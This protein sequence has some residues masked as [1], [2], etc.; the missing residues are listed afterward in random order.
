M[1][2]ATANI[3][4]E[5]KDV[6]MTISDLLECLDTFGISAKL[7]KGSP[8]TVITG[9]TIDSRTAQ[10]GDL[11]IAIKGTH[12]DGHSFI[13]DA[14]KKGA[15]AVMVE[16][17]KMDALETASV[18]TPG[19]NPVVIAVDDTHKAAAFAASAFYGFPTEKLHLTGVTGTNGKTSTTILIEAIYRQAGFEVGRIG[20]IGYCWKE[21]FI[22]AP[23]TTPDP[24]MLQRLFSQMVSD[25]VNRVVMEVSS[26]ALAQ[27]RIFG[28][29][30]DIAVFTNLSHDHLDFHETMEDYFE[31]KSLLFL[32]HLGRR[33]HAAMPAAAGHAVINID[34]PYG[35]RLVGMLEGKDV[36]VLTY[37]ISSPAHCGIA[38]L[39]YP[40]HIQ[41]CADST[42]LVVKTPIGEVSIRS[43]LIGRLNIYNILAAVG[44]GIASGIDL[45]II[46]RGI[47]SVKAVDGRLQK[48]SVDAPFHVIVDY[49]HT[50]DAMEK[51]LSC[52]RELAK[53]RVIT[54]FGC[55][56]DRDRTKRPLMAKVA[57]D[58]SDVVIITSD[59]PRTE[60]PQKIIDDILAGMPSDWVRDDL[61]L[62]KKV[63]SV[64]IDRRAAIK[65]A[66]QIAQP[67]D[68]VFIGGKGHET[69]QIIGREKIP[70]DDRCVVKECYDE[71]K[72][73]CEKQS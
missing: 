72:E 34:D 3:A 13:P 43:N 58:F 23:L 6:Q 25:G 53:G 44:A 46:A 36:E 19:E 2:M 14:I 47:A 59:N 28:C 52:V 1:T 27:K 7:V 38:P 31:A 70:F 39:I 69:Y 64:I 63:F 50:P 5:R 37:G 30:Y 4:K 40:V 66:I 62:P 60:D 32:E 73:T 21:N 11:F 67:G 24:I 15:V 17:P 45:E 26:H 65:R 18:T 22:Q 42:S 71:L 35:A 55:G 20:T 68:V 10:K 33:R 8:K 57:A 51:A 9:V 16:N 61:K 41:G 29:F 48:V 56:G 49:A 54:V 12:T